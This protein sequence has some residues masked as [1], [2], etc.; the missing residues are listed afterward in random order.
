MVA[1]VPAKLAFSLARD[2]PKRNPPVTVSKSIFSSSSVWA[3][4]PIGPVD[5]HPRQF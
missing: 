1:A 5:S 2:L 3:E 4:L